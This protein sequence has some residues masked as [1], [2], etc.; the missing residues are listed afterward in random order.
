MKAEAKETI[1]VQDRTSRSPP[2][3]GAGQAGP[4]A[5]NLVNDMNTESLVACQGTQSPTAALSGYENMG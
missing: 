4:G 1:S 2:K 5:V 3:A